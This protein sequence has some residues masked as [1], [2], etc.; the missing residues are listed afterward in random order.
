MTTRRSAV[1][2]APLL[3]GLAACQAASNVASYALGVG[4]RQPIAVTSPTV[5]MPVFVAGDAL[6]SVDRDRLAEFVDD[7]LRAGGG[8]LEVA[9]PQS[10]GRDV[11][12]A[13]A[14]LVREAAVQRGVRPYE[15]QMRLT[16]DP[17]GT[18]LIVSYE[19]YAAQGP[20]C[21]DYSRTA[22]NDR[23]AAHPNHGCAYQNNI[24]AM[25]SNPADL[26]RPSA[27]TPPDANR[28]S[29]VLEAYRAGRQ[30]EGVL[31]PQASRG[32]SRIIPQSD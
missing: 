13:Q 8:V 19:R 28:R 3:L 1:L 25:V 2:A 30:A 17:P 4:D 29:A 23:N 11:A 6:A 20:V 16:D 21:G 31:G 5:R 7:F 26:L 22:A 18:P 32:V 27:E 24:A 12:V 9:V 14:S 15:V 10:I